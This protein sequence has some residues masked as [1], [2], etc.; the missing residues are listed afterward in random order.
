MRL[1]AALLQRHALALAGGVFGRGVRLLHGS[2]I[3]GERIRRRL[4]EAQLSTK[5]LSI[6]L[7]ELDLSDLA[8]IRLAVEEIEVALATS[9]S[10]ALSLPMSHPLQNKHACDHA[11][12]SWGAAPAGVSRRPPDEGKKNR[13]AKV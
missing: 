8:S 4:I 11:A 12:T 7:I 6:H 3:K 5:P 9:L 2:S 10:T 13:P 1:L